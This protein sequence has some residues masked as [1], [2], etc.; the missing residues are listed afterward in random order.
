MA[1]KR[2]SDNPTRRAFLQRVAAGSLAGI[3]GA[4]VGTAGATTRDTRIERVEIES[5]DG[6]TIV[7]SVYEPAGAA[8]TVNDQSYPA[9]LMTH[10]WGSDRMG[11]AQVRMAEYYAQN[12]YVVLVYD[13]RG[14]GESDGTVGLNGPNEVRD[15]SALISWLGRR[16]TVEVDEPIDGRVNPRVGMDGSSYAGGLQL[17]V[18]AAD[19]RLDAIVPRLA[20][21]DLS[22]SFAP[23]GVIK[24]GWAT[25]LYVTG[26]ADSRGISL[27]DMT[28][29]FENIEHGV[30][31]QLHEIYR[32]TMVENE[33]TEDAWE[34]LNAR[35][36]IEKLDQIDIPTLFIAG[37]SDT[38][39]TPQEAIRNYRE[40][41][42]Q[43]VETR[44]LLHDGGHTLGVSGT[45]GGTA[46]YIDDIARAWMDTHLTDGTSPIHLPP[47]IYYQQQSDSWEAINRFPAAEDGLTFSLGSAAL[48]THS[49]LVNTVVSTS[50][51]QHIPILEGGVTAVSFDFPVD[52]PFELLG[53]PVLDVTIAPLGPETRLFAMLSRIHNENETQ[54]Y[55]QVTPFRVETE[56]DTAEELMERKSKRGLELQSEQRHIE[57]VVTQHQFDSDDALRLTLATTD[58]AFFASRTSLGAIVYHSE[59]TPATLSV[60]VR[61]RD[62]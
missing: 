47:I 6:T 27:K 52:E 62:F 8:T 13:S 36:P 38:L 12:G 11:T 59:E 61:R 58:D 41:R 5:F 35:S 34:Y 16:S 17:T 54:L 20:W 57:L 51:N 18:A 56:D 49:L 29:S 14:F 48:G 22:Y 7:G 33:L 60:P 23:D 3:V 15:T 44:L 1:R 46:A 42:D 32:D 37:W 24:K 53:P 30:E 10:A 40:L 39:F 50:M 28:L 2:W 21:H 19:D 45:S 9:V 55:N 4:S 25:L 31:P 26:I 43:D